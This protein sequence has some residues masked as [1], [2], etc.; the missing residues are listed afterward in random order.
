MEWAKLVALCLTLKLT[1][2]APSKRWNLPTVDLGYEIHQAAVYNEELKFYNFSNIP[3]AAPPL[4]EL[5]FA[6]P[7]PPLK[8]TSS[9]PNTGAG[10]KICPQA[11]PGN[12]EIASAFGTDYIVELFRGNG[13][14]NPDL[15]PINTTV[16]PF[17]YT[18]NPFET[19][20]CL[21]LDVV[22]PEEIF[23]AGPSA[24]APVLVQ[25]YGGG[26]VFGD[27]AGLTG[28]TGRPEGLLERS[29][30]KIIYVTMNYRLGAFGWSAGPT[31]QA[32]GGT[33]NVGLLDQRAAI[34]WVQKYISKF[35]GDPEMI[36]LIGESAGGGSIQ[37]QITAYGGNKGPNPFQRAIPQSPGFLPIRSNNYTEQT[38][39]DFLRYANVS[40]LEELRALPTER[41]L[42]ANAQQIY[43]TKIIGTFTYGPV[44][45]GDFVPDLP[46]NLLA[47]GYFDKNVSI[48]AGHNMRE[49]YTFT[50]PFMQN[51]SA[52]ISQLK[53]IFP[54]APLDVLL[55]VVTDLYPAIYDGSQP[56]RNW[57]ERAALMTTEFSFICN[58]Y[59]MTS[60][61]PNQSYGYLFNIFPALHGED[62]PYTYYYGYPPNA[63]D[64]SEVQNANAAYTL[65]D[66]ELS[67][68]MGG[69]PT[70]T[71]PGSPN[72]PLY[73]NN[74][75]IGMLNGLLGSFQATLGP[76]NANNDRCRWWQKALYA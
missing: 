59:Y 51:D 66:W 8:S 15:I 76:D 67:F 73:A 11:I 36:T 23:N 17:S 22:V 65:Q 47:Y 61:V 26:Y 24:K 70:T 57:F 35:G 21:Y 13:T 37:H 31:F 5:R 38:F 58:D 48:L 25:I 34:E 45:D 40:S 7:Q 63:T 72:L 12:I 3:F 32:S 19:E 64:F 69:A 6:A 2:A 27:K 14:A 68:A 44:V 55:Y 30:N 33:A 28:T 16:A 49:G 39:L 52:V 71:V 62:V 20:D 53:S 60:A 41:L 9:E 18:P 43:N 42:A 50:S 29:G 56:Y 4:G 1:A 46:G 54:G 10:I 74:S 75:Q